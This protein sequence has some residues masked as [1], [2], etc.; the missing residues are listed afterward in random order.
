M[1]SRKA[2][3]ILFVLAV[4][5]GVFIAV[6]I[7]GCAVHAECDATAF[8]A[9]LEKTHQVSLTAGRPARD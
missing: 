4:L 8:K 6:G 9:S 1:K 5:I 2:T 3:M 7:S